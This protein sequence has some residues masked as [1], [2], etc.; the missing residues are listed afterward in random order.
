MTNHSP[1]IPPPAYPPSD[2]SEIHGCP[3]KP[4]PPP[5]PE[6]VYR[7]LR[8]EAMVAL[9]RAEAAYR[10]IPTERQG[11]PD[12]LWIQV[13]MLAALHPVWTR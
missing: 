5:D 6:V 9:D 4:I 13:S 2:A 8:E 10:A 3:T 12:P 1:T 11:L 7:R